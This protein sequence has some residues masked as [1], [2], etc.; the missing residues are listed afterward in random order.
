VILAGAASRPIG[1]NFS[2]STGRVIG[3]VLHV[4]QGNGSPWAL[5]NNPTTKVSA[6]GWIAKDG[7]LEQYLD[8]DTQT[9][10]AQAAGNYAP[11]QGNGPYVGFETEG[12]ATEALTEAQ[13]LAF[14]GVLHELSV[15]FG[16]PLALVDHGQPGFTPHCFLSG[17]PDPN[18]GNHSC[19]GPVR[20]G[21]MPA[22][23]AA[24]TPIPPMEDDDMAKHQLFVAKGAAGQGATFESDGS[25]YR[26][27][28]SQQTL[29]DFIATET[30]RTGAAPAM[31]GGGAVAANLAA[32]GTP[33]D[34]ATAAFVGVTFP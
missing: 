2:A 11:P 33:R 7:T 12:F 31:Y 14:A 10:W 27:L 25:T 4:Q 15:H 32:F 24:A 23:L 29:D 26:W 8:P 17:A 28:Q 30:A 1:T 21:Q 34:H 6:T 16:F 3:V 5:F 18:W 19:P 13:I 9:G 22:I 20:L